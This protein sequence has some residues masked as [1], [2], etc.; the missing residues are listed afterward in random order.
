MDLRIDIDFFDN[1]FLMFVLDQ[2]AYDYEK[3]NKDVIRMTLGKSELPLHPAITKS[4]QDALG[5]FR[6]S[7][8]VYPGGLPELKDKLSEYHNKKFNIRTKPNNFLIS[9]GTSTIF[10]NLFQIL[11]KEGDE[12]LL[13]IPYYSLYHFSAL[14]S[15]AKIRYYKIDTETM[16]LDIDSFKYNFN[17]KTRIVVINSPGNPLGNI[18]T[19]DELRAIDAIVD[20]KAVIINDEI[21]ENICFDE[22]CTS[23]MQLENTKSTFI[24]TNAFSKGYRM[25]SR[26]VGYCILPDELVMPL[27]VIQH[28]TLLTLDPIVQYGAITALDYQDEVRYLESLYKARRD[29]TVE[30]FKNLKGVKALFSKGGFYITLDCS[31]YMREHK[32]DS[33]LD[34]A[35]KIMEQKNVATVPGSDFGLPYTLRLSFSSSKY[36]EGVNLLVDFFS[37]G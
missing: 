36:N 9:V 25:Y 11:L 18:L 23:V 13:P 29:Y 33:S 32:I 7:M 26:R 6:K 15:G 8:L 5:D 30:C 28:H 20:G 10:R 19:L 34:L 24:T 27:T 14:L 1:R 12:V 31:E 4:M 21:Y 22:Q 35:V 2:M 16:S 3:D 17:D 37:K